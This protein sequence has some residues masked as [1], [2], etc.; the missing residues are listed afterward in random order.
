MPSR[1]ASRNSASARPAYL[2][3][4]S[5][6][7]M[8]NHGLFHIP[9]LKSRQFFCGFFCFRYYYFSFTT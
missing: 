1:I 9:A 5:A 7:A 2:A 3:A 4:G 8:V 6:E